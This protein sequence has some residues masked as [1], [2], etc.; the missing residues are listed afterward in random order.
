MNESQE[1]GLGGDFFLKKKGGVVL[2]STGKHIEFV[3]LEFQRLQKLQVNN[4]HI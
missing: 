1:K 2:T 4:Q 3:R